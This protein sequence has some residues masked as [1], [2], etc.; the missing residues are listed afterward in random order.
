MWFIL[1][2]S[3]IKFETVLEMGSPRSVQLLL[4]ALC[5]S[6]SLRYNDWR[7]IND[8]ESVPS[9]QPCVKD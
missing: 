3:H 6:A 1:F 4:H 5:D 9:L 8:P 2:V 7:P